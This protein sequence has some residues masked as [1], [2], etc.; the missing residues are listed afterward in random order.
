MF[1][2]EKNVEKFKGWH[3]SE[4]FLVLFILWMWK[5][6]FSEFLSS[7]PSKDSALRSGNHMAVLFFLPRYMTLL[8]L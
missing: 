2:R 8:F 5:F 4:K 1:V 7:L 6:C 3:E